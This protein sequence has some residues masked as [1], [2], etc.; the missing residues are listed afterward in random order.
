MLSQ[1]DDLKPHPLFYTR[2]RRLYQRKTF[3]IINESSNDDKLY[4]VIERGSNVVRRLLVT[5]T[6]LE[7]LCNTLDEISSGK[8]R[9]PF[10]I[11]LHGRRR[12]LWIWKGS[13]RWGKFI[14]LEGHSKPGVRR[15]LQPEDEKG[16]EW[17]QVATTLG[18]LGLSKPRKAPLQRGSFQEVAKIGG[19]PLDSVVTVVSGKSGRMSQ[20][21]CIL[22][23]ADWSI[24]RD[25]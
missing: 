9:S 7:L 20:S 10:P 18:H 5:R 14:K 8:K 19:W 21:I 17:S 24:C 12:S 15:L 13:N 1:I 22:V 16:E 2:R 4:Q 23:K 3:E 11:G 6:E 25:A